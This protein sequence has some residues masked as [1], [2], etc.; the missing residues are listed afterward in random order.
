[1]RPLYKSSN[2][3]LEIYK[4]KASHFPPQVHSMIEF[5]YI[6]EGTLELGIGQELYHMEKG[7]FVVI[8]P[9]LIRHGQVFSGGR[10]TYIT[11]LASVSL[12]GSLADPLRQYQ[13][14]EPIIPSAKVHPDIPYLIRD[15]LES[16]EDRRNSILTQSF[17]QIILERAL[18]QYH[19]IQRPSGENEDLIYRSVSYIAAHFTEPLSLTKMAKDL[20]VSP[21]A[22]SR[23]FSGT[24]HM[25]FNAYLN[26]MRLEYVC[27]LLRYTDQ[28]ITDAWMNA[29]FESQR[30]FNRVF[31]EK[32]HMS[33]REFRLASQKGLDLD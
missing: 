31:Q 20:Y 8:F 22:I 33:P 16:E 23:M 12:A 29:G 18:P 24:F 13:P 28:P 21:Y 25:N 4:R 26:E 1:M 30:T 10:N 6:T 9:G 15:L 2:N 19:L 32:I 5:V 17:I 11:I 3:G 7:D 27:S 14:E